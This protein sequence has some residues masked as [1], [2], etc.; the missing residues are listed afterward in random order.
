MMNSKEIK[1]TIYLN[2]FKMLLRRKII[3]DEMEY[4]E[5]F[6]GKDSFNFTSNQ[7]KIWF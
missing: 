2:F 7:K 6:K 3:D 4:F 5:K 1:E